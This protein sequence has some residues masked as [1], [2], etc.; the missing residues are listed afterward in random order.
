M[1]NDIKSI[2]RMINPP[3]KTKNAPTFKH[4]IEA[5]EESK[6]NN[7]TVEENFENKYQEYI[8]K[9]KSLL[10]KAMENL[11]KDS[12]IEFLRQSAINLTKC[13]EIKK[14][15]PEPYFL[16]AHIFSM[17]EEQKMALSYI[18]VVNFIDPEYP[19]LKE[20]K[21]SFWGGEISQKVESSQVLNLFKSKESKEH[22]SIRKIT[23]LS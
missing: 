16:L 5:V 20:L 7:K 11:Q 17:I 9:G 21:E 15:R 19:G 10:I 1:I 6:V 14:D 2:R 3:A 13:T 12:S 22:K 23:K 18:N 4:A 8:K